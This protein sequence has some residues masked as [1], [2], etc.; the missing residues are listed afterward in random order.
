MLVVLI[1]L[2]RPYPF[3]VLSFSIAILGGFA[4]RRTPTDTIYNINIPVLGG[5]RTYNDFPLNEMSGRMIYCY[6]RTLT[7]EVIEHTELR[8][9]ATLFFVSTVLSLLDVGYGARPAPGA[10]AQRARI[11]EPA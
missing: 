3:V 10:E 11:A 6:E 8:S 9:V 5:V 1:A 7:A 2:R 4:A